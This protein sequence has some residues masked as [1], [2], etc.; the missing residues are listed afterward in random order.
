MKIINAVCDKCSGLGY[1]NQRITLNGDG[2]KIENEIC[3]KCNGAGYTR[4]YAAF[5]V[6]EAKAILKYCGLTTES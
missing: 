4:E 3:D 1:I 2:V 5:T 6:E